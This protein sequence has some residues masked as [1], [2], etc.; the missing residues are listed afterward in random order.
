MSRARGKERPLAAPEAE[1]N[2]PARIGLVLWALVV[3]L[4]FFLQPS[5]TDVLLT[6]FAMLFGGGR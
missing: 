1:D 3:V 2:S 6:L 4:I 5:T